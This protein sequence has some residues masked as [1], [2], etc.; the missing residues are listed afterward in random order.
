MM[1]N[2]PD[3][4]NSVWLAMLIEYAAMHGTLDQF[5]LL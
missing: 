2:L 3:A 5:G 4:E 1:I